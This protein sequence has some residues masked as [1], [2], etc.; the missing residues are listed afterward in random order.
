[1][2]RVHSFCTMRF[3]WLDSQRQHISDSNEFNLTFA[4]NIFGQQ[5]PTLLDVTCCVRCM[6]YKLWNC[7]NFSAN[8]SHHFSFVPWSPTHST[9][10]NVGS[11][12]TALPTLL[13]PCTHITHGLLGVNK[14]LRVVSF[15]Q[16]RVLQLPTL[17]GVDAS[18]CT[19]LPTWRQQL[20]TFLMQQYYVGSCMSVN[21]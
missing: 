2:V 19:P 9:M 12:C 1:M 3:D 10:L 11:V 15:P 18:V 14:V 17:L 4:N 5:L 16:W 6:L 20:P 21:T 13:G 8:N 7:S